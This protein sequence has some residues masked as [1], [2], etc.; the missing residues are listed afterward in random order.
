MSESFLLSD[1]RQCPGTIVSMA[2]AMMMFVI[3]IVSAVPVIAT[4]DVD[5]PFA[6]E[7]PPNVIQPK[8]N[9][10]TAGDSRK[11]VAYLFVQRDAEPNNQYAQ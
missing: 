6:C 9:Q 1:N 3:M 10:H 5:V 2:V 8:E 11:P 7:L 4:E